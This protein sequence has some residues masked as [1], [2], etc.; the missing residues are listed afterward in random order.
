MIMTPVSKHDFTCL[1]VL[2]IVA[3]TLTN[4]TTKSTPTYQLTTSSI[5]ADGGLVSPS[6][7]E[8][9]E[10][11]VIQLQATAN[12]N[13]IFNGWEGDQ[14]GSQN[15]V[16]ITMN[17][18]KNI[19]ARF[20]KREF[21]LTI[22]TEGEGTVTETIVQPKTTD[23]ESGTVVELHANSAGGWT[24]AGWQGDLQGTENPTT[25]TVDGAKTVSAVFEEI[26]F[27][28][29]AKAE[30]P[31]S[32]TVDPQ[33]VA[34]QN[35]ETVTFEAVPGN[36]AE[37]LGWFGTFENFEMVFE[38]QIIEDVDVTVF[39]STVENA[40]VIETK[41]IEVVNG[42]VDKVIFLISNFL[43]DE[44][45]LTEFTI[46]DENGTGIAG[47]VFSEPLILGARTIIE[48]T[49]TFEFE[50]TD[51]ETFKD[52]EFTWNFDYKGKNYV[53]VQEIG[54][55]SSNSKLKP[56]DM[57]KYITIEAEK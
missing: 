51:P 53:K 15:P 43:L 35:G 6:L 47:F 11:E 31:G 36:N 27:S 18:D 32:A 56:I 52:W 2:T 20:V 41:D 14:A 44:V 45:S 24:F 46:N 1:L 37:F 26:T 16:S 8:F 29:S 12:E 7:G 39:F 13:W 33:K 28:V 19:S 17:S 4:C 54:E 22:N 25:I 48:L 42:L 23:Y 5:P 38:H 34:Y 3:V 10:G 57:Q 50:T 9:D 49:V 40:F 30:G 55:A 21:P